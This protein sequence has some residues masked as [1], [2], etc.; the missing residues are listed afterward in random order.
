MGKTIIM[1]SVPLHIVP[2]VGCGSV[3]LLGERATNDE[4]IKESE[5]K[6]LRDL[7]NSD[8]EIDDT[9]P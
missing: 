1:S 4:L 8:N 3:T 2:G 5:L 6:P 9:N 7:E